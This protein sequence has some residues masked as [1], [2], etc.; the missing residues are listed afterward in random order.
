MKSIIK[1]DVVMERP[2]I[3]IAVD[4]GFSSLKVI[5]EGILFSIPCDVLENTGK[6]NFFLSDKKEDYAAVNVFGKTFLIGEYARKLLLEN[7]RQKQQDIS[8]S[9]LSDFERFGTT[10]FEV[11]M[12]AAIGMGLVKYCELSQEKGLKPKLTVDKLK[13]CDIYLA[14]AIP[15]AVYEQGAVGPAGLIR[16]RIYGHQAFTLELAKGN[17]ELDF[18]IKE[19]CA[20]KMQSQVIAA[21]LGALYDEHGEPMQILDASDKSKP[22]LVIDGGYKTVGIFKLSQTDTVE[23]AESNSAFAMNLVDEKITK[24]LADKGRAD[25]KPYNIQEYYDT[26]EEIAVIENGKSKYITINDERDRVIEEYCKIMIEYLNEKYNNLIAIKQILITGGTGAAYYDTFIEY[27]NSNDKMAH[28][29]GKVKLAEYK[30]MGQ[31]ITPIFAVVTGIY[32]QFK[33][34]LEQQSE[35][36]E[37]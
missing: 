6:E 26:R 35:A 29:R 2:I 7:N 1:E 5:C 11:S 24:I 9:V 21:L 30:F 28:L 25:I 34:Y 27:I 3:R 12:M 33:R 31:K 4:P 10:N 18:T 8:Y 17:Y 14:I 32:K 13:D 22:I 16:D 19:D 23:E 20:Y 36:G 37:A 15:H